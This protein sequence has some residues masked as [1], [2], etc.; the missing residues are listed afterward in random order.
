MYLLLIAFI[1]IFLTTCVKKED[2]DFNK[3]T[4]PEWSPDFSI[5]LIYTSLDLS[6]LI[7][8]ADNVLHEDADRFLTLVYRKELLSQKARDV[9]EVEDQYY[10]NSFSFTIPSGFDPGNVVS[11]TFTDNIHFGMSNNEVLDNIHLQQ[12][13]LGVNILTD[14]NHD[15]RI[16]VRFP[17]VTKNG[18]SYRKTLW[19]SYEGGVSHIDFNYNFKDYVVGLHHHGGNNN[20]VPIEFYVTVYFDESAPNNSPYFFDYEVTFLN[21]DYNKMKGFLNYKEFSFNPDSVYID[22][23]ENSWMGNFLLQNPKMT[24]N[25]TNSLGLPLDIVFDYLVAYNPNSTEMLALT[26]VPSVLSVMH[27]AYPGDVTTTTLQLDGNNSNIRDAINLTPHY[28][29]FEMEG[30]ANPSGVYTQNFVLDTSAFEV[31]LEI[32]LPL[33]GRAW[34]FVIQDTISFRFESLDQI[35]LANFKVNITNGFPI[36]A[37]IQ[38]YFADTTY[39]IID[40]LFTEKKELILAAPVGP[41]PEYRVTERRFKYTEAQLNA[42]RLKNMSKARYMLINASLATTNQG[43]DVVKV[44]SDYFIDVSLAVQTKLKLDLNDL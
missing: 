28:I 19:Q 40:S 18:T 4:Y 42:R 33:Y 10:D 23:F 20:Q 37:N 2:F 12:G 17:T 13:E 22:I 7:N 32:E 39:N 16:E 8:A 24:I 43:A 21:M 27:P 5:P 14:I 11:T 41:A 25:I 26:G 9:F 34:D 6:M 30:I 1:S 36:D 35:E 3:L 15:M 44:Y 38:I 31:D 29:H